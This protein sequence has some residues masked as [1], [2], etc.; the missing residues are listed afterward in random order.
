MTFLFS[1]VISW[2]SNVTQVAEKAELRKYRFIYVTN[3]SIVQFL[4]DV[5]YSRQQMP[6]FW[7]VV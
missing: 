1:N 5:P 3:V 4:Q 7:T 2:S 6:V